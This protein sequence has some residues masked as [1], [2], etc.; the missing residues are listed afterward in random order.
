[1]RILLVENDHTVVN[2][3]MRL[4]SQNHDFIPFLD[5]DEALKYVEENDPV[6]LIMLD[7]RMNGRGRIGLEV[8][9]L[10]RKKWGPDI[11]TNVITG[12]S[13][14][15]LSQAEDIAKIDPKFAVS[16]KPLTNAILKSIFSVTEDH[17]KRLEEK[18]KDGSSQ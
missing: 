1:M 9:E 13:D 15:M 5:L 2:A 12:C 18:Q 16:L 7:L 3:I 17:L 6:D 10:A 4:H 8:Y 14:Q 11:F